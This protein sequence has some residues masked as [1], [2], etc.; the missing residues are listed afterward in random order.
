[1]RPVRPRFWQ[2]PWLRAGRRLFRCW[3]CGWQGWLSGGEA[4]AIEQ[5]DHPVEDDTVR[6]RRASG[7]A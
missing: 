7:T 3:H 5:Q 4:D 1:V 6:R 2:V